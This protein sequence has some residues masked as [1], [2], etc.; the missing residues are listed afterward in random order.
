MASINSILDGIGGVDV[1]SLTTLLDINLTQ[2]EN[3]ANTFEPK[4]IKQSPYFDIDKLV[5]HLKQM[6][7][8][9]TIIS[10]NCES[11]N[12]KFDELKIPK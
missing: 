3:D 5:L 8:H 1:N 4:L 6:Q 7:N 2:D 9:F 10:L 11:L 12:A